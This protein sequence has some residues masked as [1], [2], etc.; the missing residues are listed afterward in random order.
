MKSS[1]VTV[2][3]IDSDKRFIDPLLSNWKTSRKQV[4][5]DTIEGPQSS[6]QPNRFSR[7]WHLWRE[8]IFFELMTLRP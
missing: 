4:L 7:A 3:E 6:G 8:E 5:S 2:S 1:K